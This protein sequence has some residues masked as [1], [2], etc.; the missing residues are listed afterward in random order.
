LIDF[1]WHAERIVS[2]NKDSRMMIVFFKLFT[3]KST[4]Q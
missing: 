4:T 3:P 1:A 2:S